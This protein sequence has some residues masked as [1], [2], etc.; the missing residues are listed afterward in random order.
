MSFNRLAYD[1]CAYRHSLNETIGPGEYALDTNNSCEP[2]FVSD[3]TVRVQRFGASICPK[4]LID[5][6]SEL[7]G[8]TRRASLCPDKQYLPKDSPFCKGIV[9]KE[10]NAMSSEPTRL[11]N[12]ACDLRCTG[13]N[14]FE[15]L[16]IDEQLKC[17][18]QFRRDGI[19]SRIIIKDEHRPCVPTPLSQI[20][21][22]PKAVPQENT[23]FCGSLREVAPI[24][25]RTC[26]EL[27]EL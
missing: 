14:R 20:A 25:W 9:L 8:I 24:H 23:K 13:W 19:S 18:E 16:C 21:A 4:D 22:L 27:R 12:P 10:C 15:P 7:L 6:D 3:P 26:K 1:T 17:L 11:S 5:V 2:C